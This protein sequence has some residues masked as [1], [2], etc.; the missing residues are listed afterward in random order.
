MR[1]TVVLSDVHLWEAVAGDDLWMRYRQQRFFPDATIARLLA[2]L[3]AG[4]PEG[5]IEL[6]L[7]GDI[8][9]FD[10]PRADG[11]DDVPHDEPAAALRVDRILDDHPVFID[12][13]ARLLVGGHRVVFVSGNHDVQLVYPAVRARI[14]A[15]LE[16]ATGALDGRGVAASVRA[17]VLFRAWF[18]RTRD[19]VHIEHGHQYD[20]YCASRYP[21]SPFVPGTGRVQPTVSSLTMRHLAGRF[22]YF[23]PNVDAT[24]LLTLPGYV[25]HWARYYLFSPRSLVLAWLVGTLRVVAELL[26]VPHRDEV[27]RALGNLLRTSRETG[28]ALEALSEH[29]AL[30]A[31]QDFLRAA[32][33]LW[34]DKIALLAAIAAAVALGLVHLPS[35]LLLAA[36]TAVAAPL[37]ARALPRG[38]LEEVYERLEPTQ[39]EIASI[40][41]ARA[42]VFGHT[43]IPRGHWADGV[44]VG[45]CGT[46]APMYHDIACTR[47][48][49]HGFPFVWLRA[50]EEG[51]LD[52]GLYRITDGVI[53]PVPGATRE[54]ARHEDDDDR[55]VAAA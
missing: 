17:R 28:A 49:Q 54:V 25:V 2:S 9:D 31:R 44:F 6:V 11:A 42:V 24:F 18:H 48:M 27:E 36:F 39:R 15:R 8:F 22:G 45:N 55:E 1:H 32:R 14:L 20:P 50:H 7:D 37:A 16:R 12:A 53:A 29:A 40:H 21:Q 35:G 51:A 41:R 10:V 23:N 30:F 43:H 3:T 26:R 34:V 33:I 46:W 4:V 13:L 38:D 52:G 47:P 5:D 19:G